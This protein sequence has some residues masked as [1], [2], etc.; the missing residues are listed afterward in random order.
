[1]G[2]RNEIMEIRDAGDENCRRRERMQMRKNADEKECR[3][4]ND[5]DEK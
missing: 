4:E 2:I 1:M 5:G 3:W